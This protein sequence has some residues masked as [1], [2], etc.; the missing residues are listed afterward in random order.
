MPVVGPL[1]VPPPDGGEA[2]AAG[3]G[4]PACVDR[5][6]FSS[7]EFFSI[8]TSRSISITTSFALLSFFAHLSF[9][10]DSP[11]ERF[12]QKKRKSQVKTVFATG[13]PIMRTFDEKNLGKRPPPFSYT[14]S[15]NLGR[16]V[17]VDRAE[18]THFAASAVKF[19]FSISRT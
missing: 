9:C 4:A 16:R 14:P 12:F 19:F 11:S 15:K 2:H 6:V 13:S 8:T 5:E 7:N 18:H 1:Q 17:C 10:S 3:P